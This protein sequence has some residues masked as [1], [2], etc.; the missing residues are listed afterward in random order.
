MFFHSLTLIALFLAIVAPNPPNPRSFGLAFRA[1]N[2][3]CKDPNMSNCSHRCYHA[4]K[5]EKPPSSTIVTI[6]ALVDQ[7]GTPQALP[8]STQSRRTCLWTFSFP[9][10]SRHT[11]VAA[12][13]IGGLCWGLA[14]V[15]Y[16][17][18]VNRSTS[19]TSSLC[20]GSADCA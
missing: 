3:L 15:H 13:A 9:L 7:N 14:A 8:I 17:T 4:S 11:L 16:P 20:V 1:F 12:R 5:R 10:W 6:V 2:S 18:W 19:K